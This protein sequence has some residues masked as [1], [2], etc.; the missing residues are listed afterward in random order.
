MIALITNIALAVL[1]L[2]LSQQPTFTSF[3]LG[4][5]IVFG[6]IA[7]FSKVFGGKQYVRR[8]LGFAQF[9]IL[10]SG[11]FIKANLEVARLVLFVPRSKYN[12]GFIDYSI[13]DMTFGEALLLSHCITLTPGTITA[14]FDWNRKLLRIHILDFSDSLVI[15]KD[16]DQKLKQVIWKFSR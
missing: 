14:L 1:W 9:L 2:M 12:S 5:L 15:Q 4:Y 16:I 7:L 10:F 11:Q 13:D 6:L 3:I 8:T